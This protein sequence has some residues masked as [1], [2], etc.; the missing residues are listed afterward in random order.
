[1]PAYVAFLRGVS[2]MNAS[3]LALKR[4][5][6]AAGFKEV[7]TVLASGNVVFAAR[8]AAVATLERKCVA[9]MQA[10]MGRSFAAIVRP[11]ED[12]RRMLERDPFAA[13]GLP[14]DAKRI[15]TFLRRPPA[16][17]PALPLTMDGASILELAGQEVFSAYVPSP[18]GPVFMALIEKTF[19]ADVTTRTWDTVRKCVAASGG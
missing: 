16:A 8:T 9:A 5:W 13:H 19:G 15:V 2:P 18:R 3:M 10:A 12:L 17:A 1:M 6:E 11:V 14:A 4:A 7:K